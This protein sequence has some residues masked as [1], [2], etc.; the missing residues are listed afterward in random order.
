MVKTLKTFH[1]KS[2]DEFA[3][4]FAFDLGH[5]NLHDLAFVHAGLLRWSCAARGLPGAWP[6]GFLPDLGTLRLQ[7]CGLAVGTFGA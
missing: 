2:I 1:H 5:Q 6:A 3:V 4:G 7:G